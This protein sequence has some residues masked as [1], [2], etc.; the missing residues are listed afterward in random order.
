[1]LLTCP[2]CSAKYSVGDGAIPRKGRTVRCAA[3]QHTWRQLPD[4]S[5]DASFD[6]AAAAKNI[7][8]NNG[9]RQRPKSV[10]QDPLEP[11]ARMRKRTHDKIELVNRLAVALPWAVA[12]TFVISGGLMALSYRTDIVRSWPKS[13]SVFAAIGLP[14]NLY[15]I[16]IGR[17]QARPT[18]DDKGPRVLVAGVLTSVSRT[19]EPV[20]Y[21]KVALI[22]AKGEEKLAWMVDPGVEILAPGKVHAFQTGRANPVRGDLTAV[23]TFAEPPPKVPRAPP[24][25]PEPPTGKSG[26]MGAKAPIATRPTIVQLRDKEP[27][28]DPVT[29]R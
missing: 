7:L 13:A 14:A 27:G 12:T 6:L 28:I 23:V 19:N 10:A 11:H 4:D 8:P 2:E 15:G 26:L 22:N 16:D 9:L 20:P 29:A 3:C 25:A 21:L 5:G 24:P 18:Q 17:V 1:M